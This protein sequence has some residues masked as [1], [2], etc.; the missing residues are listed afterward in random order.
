MAAATRSS[1]SGIFVASA[2]AVPAARGRHARR[3]WHCLAQ[4][5]VGVIGHVGAIDAALTRC[6]GK[7]CAGDAGQRAGVMCGRC[8]HQVRDG[9]ILDQQATVPSAASA[10]SSAA[11]RP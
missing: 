3:H 2:S 4:G 10:A 9:A 7:L 5:E 8:E 11:R 1:L 6:N